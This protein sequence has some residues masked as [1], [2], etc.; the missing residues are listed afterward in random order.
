MYIHVDWWTDWIVFLAVSAV[1]QPFNSGY[2]HV[3]IYMY[4]FSSCLGINLIQKAHACSLYFQE[5]PRQWSHC[6]T[7]ASP[8]SPNPKCF[9]TDCFW[10]KQPEGNCNWYYIMHEL[11]VRAD[12]D[13]I[14]GFIVVKRK[15]FSSM[16]LY[17]M[18]TLYVWFFV[19]LVSHEWQLTIS[20][21][22]IIMHHVYFKNW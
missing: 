7:D 6:G 17:F 1:F 5:E 2:I 15:Y 16:G 10:R 18:H 11:C 22:I 20:L 8:R 21:L 3:Y 12:S 9:R 14:L 13:S 19:D 4:I